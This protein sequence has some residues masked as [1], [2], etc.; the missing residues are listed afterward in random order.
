M[1]ADIRQIM[2]A[3]LPALD[4]MEFSDEPPEGYDPPYG[5]ESINR[6]KPKTE[7]L[8]D[9]VVEMQAYWQPRN[10]RLQFIDR[11]WRLTTPAP[12][13]DWEQIIALPDPRLDVNKV[14]VRLGSAALDIQ[15]E[16]ATP[17]EVTEEAAQRE[18]DF[19]RW[20]V[21]RAS[22]MHSEGINNPLQYEAAFMGLHRGAMCHVILPNPYNRRFPWTIIPMDWANVYPTPG[23]DP[24]RPIVCVVP[25]HPREIKKLFPKADVDPKLGANYALIYYYD[26]TWMGIY[27]GGIEATATSNMIALKGPVRHG[28]A[29]NPLAVTPIN[30]TPIRGTPWD[31][32]DY[33][34]Y[35]GVPMLDPVAQWVVEFD[36]VLSRAF[37]HEA[38]GFNPPYMVYWDKDANQV[39][40]V[41]I[42]LS[43]NAPNN[44][45]K[46]VQKVEIYN[47]ASTLAETVQV[48]SI[49]E[50]RQD[51]FVPPVLYG[52]V[53]ANQSGYATEA[54]S[55]AASDMFYPGE[56]G[57][58]VHY[59]KILTRAKNHMGNNNV[60]LRGVF[61]AS[62]GRAI[63]YS[64]EDAQLETEMTVS[65]IDITSRD[66]DRAVALATQAVSAGL[67]SVQT[68]V[69]WSKISKNPRLEIK[70]ILSEMM[71]KDP[72]LLKV[73]V[74]KALR[75]L[76]RNEDL[77]AFMQLI[78]PPQKQGEQGQG[79]NLAAQVQP[80]QPGADVVP[81]EQMGNSEATQVPLEGQQLVPEVGTPS[82]NY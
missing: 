65:L 12:G 2:G 46:G 4:P 11:L 36:K 74:V 43:P 52:K 17:I 33:V 72:E 60:G 6:P 73:Q 40:T 31:S 69:E 71:S 45:P 9:L 34:K 56:A 19:A 59:G 81:P 37:T 23:H 47:P 49:L 29:L 20:W 63:P 80:P 62:Q 13:N 48:L 67:M 75:D 61:I 28:Y 27:M 57:L 15:I 41:E 64:Y 50:S 79:Q 58:A 25:T 66:K 70:R 42:D 22:R 39:K 54:T 77:Q 3:N 14:A 53:G 5:P 21:S 51:K 68:A 18:E 7:E 38:K 8:G 16:A 1:V 32:A 44:L 55:D 78:T 82:G 76:G 24:G 30:G 35:I 26:D 10:N